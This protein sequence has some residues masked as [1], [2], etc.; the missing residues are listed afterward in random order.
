MSEYFTEEHAEEVEIVFQNKKGI[1]N[2]LL[3]FEKSE[4]DVDESEDNR[5][6]ASEMLNADLPIA[7]TVSEV[8]NPP[9]VRINFKLENTR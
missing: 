3:D 5:A 9:K 1:S 8:S 4:T 6:H 2:S 7:E